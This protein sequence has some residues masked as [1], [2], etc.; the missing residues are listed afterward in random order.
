[1]RN[2][3]IT[4]MLVGATLLSSCVKDTLIQN[5][6]DDGAV[7]FDVKYSS[8]MTRAVTESEKTSVR[9]YKE[10]GDLIRYYENDYDMPDPLYLVSGDYSVKVNRGDKKN[11]KAFVDPKNNTKLAKLLCYEGTAEF[12]VNA[13][14]TNNIA[15]VAKTINVRAD[16]NLDRTQGENSKLTDVSMDIVSMNVEATPTTKQDYDSLVEEAGATSLNFTESGRGYFLPKDGVNQLVWHFTANHPSNGVVEKFGVINDVAV[17]HGYTLNFNYSKTP[18]GFGIIEVIVHDD[19]DTSES[20]FKFKPE[21]EITGDGINPNGVNKYVDGSTLN[22][23][24]E[25]INDIIVITLD[26]KDI[27]AYGSGQAAVAG[28][29]CTRV[30]STKVNIVINNSYFQTLASGV[31]TLSFG[32]TDSNGDFSRKL[33]FAKQGLVDS[34]AT[35]DLWNNTASLKAIVTESASQ[36]QIRYRRSG[37]TDWAYADAVVSSDGLTYVANTEAVWNNAILNEN[38]QTVYTIN[39]NKSFFAASTYEY[40]LVINGNE[41]QSSTLTTPAGQTIPYATFE[42]SSL[43]CFGIDDGHA[44]YWG[45]GNNSFAKSLCVQSTYAGQEGSHCAKLSAVAAGAVGITMLAS[46]NVF[47]GTFN[48]PGT[49][50]TVAFGISYNWT[51]RPATLKYKFWGDLGTVDR[52]DKKDYIILQKGEQDEGSIYAVIIDWDAQHGTSS[53]TGNPGGV[54]DPTQGPNAVS[55]GKIIGYAIAHPKG[56]TSGTSMVEEELTFYY[57]DK[58]K[59]PSKKYTLTIMASTSRYGDYMNG[60]STSYM[61]VDDFR[62][63]Y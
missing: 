26:G 39:R 53:G 29:T 3:Y 52:T 10:N 25:S 27:Y 17:A 57:Y 41:K 15:V 4:L 37:T 22:L 51:A 40:Q 47:L 6:L 8:E 56:K 19:V 54:W 20:D 62:F 35:F 30:S 1:M 63:G 61:Y 36:V 46:G 24:C 11:N 44:P 7:T 33:K 28:V 18:D 5:S 50:G 45:S 60:C 9:I 12:S 38:N 34:D 43:T 31:N 32:I 49:T 21:P 14:E 42:D 59:K 48:K 2:I 23:V 13:H 55:E 16:M 58:V